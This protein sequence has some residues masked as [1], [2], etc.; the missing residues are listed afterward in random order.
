MVQVEGHP[1]SSSLFKVTGLPRWHSGKESACQCR[2]RKR[3]G[4]SPASGRSP[5]VGNGTRL[6]YSCLKNSMDREAWWATVYGATKSWTYRVNTHTH[7]FKVMS[8]KFHEHECLVLNSKQ[9]LLLFSPSY[10]FILNYL[11]IFG[12]GKRVFVA[13]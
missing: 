3:C 5:R 7:I 10:L 8:V 4:F 2:R 9:F 1:V 11:F 6:Q 12:C 13:V